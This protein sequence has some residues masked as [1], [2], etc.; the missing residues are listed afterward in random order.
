MA[1]DDDKPSR[2]SLDP[3]V[4]ELLERDQGKSL[5]QI[6]A[7]CDRNNWMD[8]GETV[9]YGLGDKVLQSMPEPAL[10]PT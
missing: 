2:P 4:K 5:E 3:K 9:A 7:D 10:R 8:A 1:P 6:T